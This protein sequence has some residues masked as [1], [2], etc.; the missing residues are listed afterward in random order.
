MVRFPVRS[1][2][3]SLI[4]QLETRLDKRA[5]LIKER[6]YGGLAVANDPRLAFPQDT[7]RPPEAPPKDVDSD[8]RPP[9]AKSDTN[10]TTDTST[11]AA[12]TTTSAGHDS[13]S[14]ASSATLMSQLSGD[15]SSSQ[16]KARRQPISIA[17]LRAEAQTGG[18][19]KIQDGDELVK[20]MAA[21]LE[22]VGSDTGALM[23]EP[24]FDSDDSDGPP[25]EEEKKEEEKE[26]IQ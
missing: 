12:S 22:T 13:H 26:V 15:S 16:S 23:D 2:I 17:D 21:M 7:E 8:K 11:T 20:I 18:P 5:E 3:Q 1:W 6:R 19:V 9:L 10:D 14:R 24:D 25:S 4:G